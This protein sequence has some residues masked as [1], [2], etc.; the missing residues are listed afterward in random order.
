VVVL[1]GADDDV[2]EA[3]RGVRGVRIAESRWNIGFPAGCNLGRAEARGELL[4]LLHDDAEA[5]EGWLPALVEAAERHPGAGVI[6][7]RV[8]SSDGSRLQLAGGVIFSDTSAAHLGRGAAPEA[9]EHMVSRPVDYCSSCSLLVRARTWDAIGGADELLFP[10]GYVDADL[11]VAAWAAGWE[12]RYEPLPAARHSSRGSMTA[13]F[14]AFTHQRSRDRFRTKWAAELERYEPP[15]ADVEAATERA[16]ARAEARAQ[17]LGSRPRP[18]SVPA[19][20]RTADPDLGPRLATLELRLLREYVAMADTELERVQGEYAT[21]H[22]ELDRV[23]SEYAS[24]HRRLASAD[25]EL[26]V[27]RER[28]RILDAILAGGWWRLRGRLLPLI[29]LVRR[30]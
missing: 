17:E 19:R 22:R 12:V 14:K 23:H 2:V 27:L 24:L 16:V 6:G 11:C 30:R 1:S 26:E 20:T 10:G 7:S 3:A 29:R 4:V 15:G 8:L 18:Q 5:N 21:A 28:A 25:A 13:G 9:P